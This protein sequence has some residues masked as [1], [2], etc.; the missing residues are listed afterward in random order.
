[1]I[2]FPIFKSIQSNHVSPE[3]LVPRAPGLA[4][5]GVELAFKSKD[6]W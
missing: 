5:S 4:G 3:P 2:G 1:M 6:E